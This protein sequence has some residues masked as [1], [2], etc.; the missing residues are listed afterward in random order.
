MN[1]ANTMVNARMA[2][3][4]VYGAGMGNIAPWKDVWINAVDM[5]GGCFLIN[6][7]IRY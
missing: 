6:T 2:L 5:A 7:G 3:V 1:G 4:C